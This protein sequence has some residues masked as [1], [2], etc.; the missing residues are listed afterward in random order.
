M[1]YSKLNSNKR[2]KEKTQEVTEITKGKSHLDREKA[3]TNKHSP[4]KRTQMCSPN[5]SPSVTWAIL[6]QTGGFLVPTISCW[7][8]NITSLFDP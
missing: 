4:Q 5:F 7:I 6:G 2:K 8:K 3:D 1:D